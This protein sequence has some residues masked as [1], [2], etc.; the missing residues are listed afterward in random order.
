MQN[1]NTRDGIDE[2]QDIGGEKGAAQQLE[3][4]LTGGLP[5]LYRRA[6]RILEMCQLFCVNDPGFV[7]GMGAR[8]KGQHPFPR[9]AI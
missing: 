4:I 9:P 7:L 6:Y 5:P 8:G 3:Q 2:Q 1:R